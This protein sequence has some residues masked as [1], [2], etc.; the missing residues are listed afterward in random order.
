MTADTANPDT[1]V[2][3]KVAQDDTRQSTAPT[4]RSSSMS[5]GFKI[6]GIVGLCLA[7]LAV[8]GA[9]AIWQ[10]DKIGGELEAIAEQDIPLTNSLTQVTIHQ[11]EQAVNFE[12]AFRFGEEMVKH[13]EI[14]KKFE[15]T[16]HHFEELSAKVEKELKLVEHQADTAAHNAHTEAEKKE[17]THVVAEL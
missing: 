6:Y 7:L 9:V 16:V 1:A 11:L 2:D 14:R 8:T 5:V 4:S 15:K 13:P 17:F 10:M 3:L 12:R